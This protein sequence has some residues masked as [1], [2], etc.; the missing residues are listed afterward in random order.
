[1]SIRMCGPG[2]TTEQKNSMRGC[3]DPQESYKGCVLGLFERNGYDDSDFCAIVWDEKLD[4]ITTVEYASTR[5][6]T[7]HNSAKVDATDAVKIQAQAYMEQKLVELWTADAERMNNVPIKGRTVRS[8]TTR[9]KNVGIEGIVMWRGEDKYSH[10]AGS[11]RV[12][13]KVNGNAK[14]TY[15]PESSVE[16]IDDVKV[17]AHEIEMMA[18][19][20]AS[21]CRWRDLIG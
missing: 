13:I 6:W 20:R 3:G 8:I 10:I 16:V 9:G 4:A 19:D 12:G 5:G 14:L 17:D 2:C 15:L 7:Y 18:R 11:Y 1:M 21:Q